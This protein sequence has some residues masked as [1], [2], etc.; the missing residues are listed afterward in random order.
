MKATLNWRLADMKLKS[1]VFMTVF[2]VL[3]SK[4]N[5]YGEIIIAIY[6]YMFTLWFIHCYSIRTE[7]FVKIFHCKLLTPAAQTLVAWIYIPM[8]INRI[9]LSKSAWNINILTTFA[10]PISQFGSFRFYALF[11]RGKLLPTV[12]CAVWI[13]SPQ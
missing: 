7:V 9:C 11:P 6:S 13:R 5:S 10:Y 12:P 4:S 8:V 2:K 1:I 3:R